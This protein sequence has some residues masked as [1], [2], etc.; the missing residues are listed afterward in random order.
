MRSF[1]CAIVLVCLPLTAAA[2]APSSDQAAVRKAITDHYF[3]AH[4]TGSGDALKGTFIDEGRM[5]WVQDGELR[6]RPS[7]EYIAGFSGKPAADEAQRKR[8][9]VMVDVTA[10]T[11]VAKVEL[12]YPDVL[13]TDYFSLLRIGGDWKIVHKTFSRAPKTPR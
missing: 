9:I 4:A 11:A 1:V 12:D 7:A 2:Q 13:L 8:R 6:V 3:K 10:D 5:M